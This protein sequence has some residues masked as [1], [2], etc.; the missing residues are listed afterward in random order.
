M[1]TGPVPQSKQQA[2]ARALRE[3]APKGDCLIRETKKSI[4]V[5]YKTISAEGKEFYAHRLVWE[6]TN[7]KS[8]EGLVIRHTCDTPACINPSHLIEGT[9]GDNVQDKL[10]R[11]RHPRGSKHYNAVLSNTFVLWLRSLDRPNFRELSANTSVSVGAL[12]AAYY[13]HTWKHVQTR[14]KQTLTYISSKE[15]VNG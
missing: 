12:K 1:K 2:V 11:D 10:R 5:G 4:S 14:A 6:V 15:F 9:H 3:A 13:G 8:P 7:N